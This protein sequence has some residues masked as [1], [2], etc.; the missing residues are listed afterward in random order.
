MVKKLSE[1]S[2]RE[3]R[4]GANISNIGPKLRAE[5]AAL[6]AMPESEID[7]SD[8]PEKLDWSN[9]ERGRFYRPIKKLV[10]V[11]VDADT[12]EWFKQQAGNGS[13]T[14]LINTALRAYAATKFQNSVKSKRGLQ[15]PKARRSA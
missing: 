10:S 13:Y 1:S 6:K 8:I 14:S 2:P 5:L 3:R 15:K 7:L 12:L 11:R 9:A 4:R